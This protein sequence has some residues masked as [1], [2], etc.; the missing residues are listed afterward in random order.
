MSARST[1]RHVS[2]SGRI[3]Y[4]YANGRF[5]TAADAMACYLDRVRAESEIRL[6]QHAEMVARSQA[7]SASIALGWGLS[8]IRLMH[9]Q[10][11]S[12]AQ[13]SHLTNVAAFNGPIG[14]RP[15]FSRRQSKREREMAT[16][17]RLLGLSK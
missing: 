9:A 4:R 11:L 16:T 6:A 10:P 13:G 8:F 2:P 12:I 5:A 17:A 15:V 1:F 3:S 14:T 7:E